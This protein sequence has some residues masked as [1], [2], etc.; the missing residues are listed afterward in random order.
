MKAKAFS[1]KR[2]GRK[3][4]DGIITSNACRGRPVNVS[5]SSKVT[6]GLADEEE[7]RLDEGGEGEPG[8]E[9]VGLGM[10]EIGE[11]DVGREM[12]AACDGEIRLVIL[13]IRNQGSLG[14]DPG[15][16]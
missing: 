12:L 2:G 7:E 13:P 3:L 6:F 14:P 16:W 9:A 4:G 10:D 1:T 15:C 5:D 8:L 11:G